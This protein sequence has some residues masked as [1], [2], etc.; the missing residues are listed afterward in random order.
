MSLA[1]R[2]LSSFYFMY[3]RPSDLFRLKKVRN[4]K[5][6][7]HDISIKSWIRIY[8][9]ACPHAGLFPSRERCASETTEQAKLS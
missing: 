9:P 5:E 7:K 4:N 2:I 6:K 8:G 1:C 3:Q